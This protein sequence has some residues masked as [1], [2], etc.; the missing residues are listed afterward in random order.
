RLQFVHLI[1]VVV[2]TQM[3]IQIDDHGRSLPLLA[4]SVDPRGEL[5]GRQVAATIGGSG[6]SGS[7]RRGGWGRRSGGSPGPGGA[8]SVRGRATSWS[9]AAPNH[10]RRTGR[11]AR[12]ARGGTWS[13]TAAVP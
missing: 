7:R 8:G 12:S 13:G 11:S 1:Q 9:R 2:L 3:R 6:R 5:N 10:R 4:R